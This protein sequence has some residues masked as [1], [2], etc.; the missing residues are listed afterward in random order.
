MPDV[1]RFI[2]IDVGVLD[3]DFL[4]GNRR[5]ILCR[6]QQTRAERRAIEANVDV[7]VACDL[8]RGN[9]LYRTHAVD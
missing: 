9:A 5:R 8:H 4:A 3:D 2:R 7:S 6:T 1:R